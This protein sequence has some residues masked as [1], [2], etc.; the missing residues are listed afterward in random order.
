MAS[1]TRLVYSFADAWTTSSAIYILDLE[2]R[3][4][5]F[6]A[7]SNALAVLHGELHGGALLVNQHRYY[8]PPNY[9]SYD[10]FWLVSSAGEIGEDLGPDFAAA[11]TKLSMAR[12]DVRWPFRI[13]EAVSDDVDVAG[14]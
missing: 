3:A 8:G 5:K 6:F 11:L 9:G 10:H 13:S 1:D 12:N 7:P 2:T 4:V 14:G